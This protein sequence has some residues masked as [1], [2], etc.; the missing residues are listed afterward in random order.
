MP[1]KGVMFNA[2]PLP[3]R[4]YLMRRSYNPEDRQIPGSVVRELWCV[5]HGMVHGIGFRL[6]GCP[7]PGCPLAVQVYSVD[8]P[9]VKENG[10]RWK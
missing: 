9:L 1:E 2:E 6:G 7:V 4:E 5:D 10:E 3:P 8:V